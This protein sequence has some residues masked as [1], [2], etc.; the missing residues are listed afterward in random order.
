MQVVIDI[1]E[2]VYTR[3]FDNGGVKAMDMHRACVAIRKGTV[4][5]KEHGNLIDADALKEEYPHDEDWDYPV[6]TNSYVV[7]S[8]DEA[9]TIIEASK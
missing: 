8:I 2:D 6:N 5:P 1:D 9:P 4:L 3:L 7:K